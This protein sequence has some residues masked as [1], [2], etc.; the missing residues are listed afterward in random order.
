MFRKITLAALIFMASALTVFAADEPDTAQNFIVAE[1]PIF[2]QKLRFK[3]PISWQRAHT[4]Q[5]E[6]SFVIE[7]IPKD[8]AI[9]N[10]E[11]LFSIQG[12][13]DFNPDVT[14]LDVANSVANNFIKNCPQ[15]A[16]YT[17]IGERVLNGHQAFLAIIGCSEMPQDHASNLKK[18][19]SEISYYVFVKGTKDLYFAQ[20][21]IRGTGFAPEK[22]PEFVEKSIRDMKNFFP[23]EFCTLDSAQGRCEK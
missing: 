1:I 2:S 11:N 17:K 8:E 12:F 3:L 15:S 13:K 5:N 4:S 9:D 20:K 21:S 18:G 22:F 19:M 23:I 10:W 7:F 6:K 14:P 16:I